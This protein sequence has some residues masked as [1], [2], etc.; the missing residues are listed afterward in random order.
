MLFGGM[1]GST[2]GGIKCIRLV[3]VINFIK[4]ELKKT[5]HPRAV[6]AIKTDAKILSSDTANAI[7]ALISVYFLAF[8]FITLTLN[9]EGID[10]VSAST[11]SISALSNIGPAF[12]QFGPF[13]NFA[14]VTDLSKIILSAGM[15]LGRLEFLTILVLFTR[16]FWKKY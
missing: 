7:W 8:I 13:D 3:A 15:L 2:S 6:M 9:F 16:E 1:S 10:L 14:N 5:L 4:V 11:A 12:G